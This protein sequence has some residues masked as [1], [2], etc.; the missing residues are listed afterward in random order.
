MSGT[1]AILAALRDGPKTNRELQDLTCDHSGSVAR[2]C[3]QL[4]DLGLVIR[5]DG[6]QG[7]GTRAIYALADKGSGR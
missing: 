2:N 3:V 5:V 4:R 6:N 7:R 1:R